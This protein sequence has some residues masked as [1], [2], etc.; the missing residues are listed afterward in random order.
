[1]D[2]L[3]L[4]VGTVNPVEDFRAILASQDADYFEEG[5]HCFVVDLF[6]NLTLASS[7]LTCSVAVTY[8]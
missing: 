3:T 5:L 2:G 7:Y 6:V 4:Q 1:M 8:L